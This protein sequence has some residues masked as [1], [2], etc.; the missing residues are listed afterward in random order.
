MRKHFEEPRHFPYFR[1]QPNALSVSATSD[2]AQ[3]LVAGAAL[4]AVPSLLSAPLPIGA[5][6]TKLGGAG[7]RFGDDVLRAHRAILP[8]VQTQNS[9]NLSA[10]FGSLTITWAW[11]GGGTKVSRTRHNRHR[12]RSK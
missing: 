9:T 11:A 6:I 4:S 5:T 1:E 8:C 2:K 3:E 10:K 7:D 12:R